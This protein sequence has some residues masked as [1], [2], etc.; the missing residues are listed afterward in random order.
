MG[1]MLTVA[2]YAP[3]AAARR[4]IPISPLGDARP[5]ARTSSGAALNGLRGA[6]TAAMKPRPRAKR[7]VDSAPRRW[8]T[9]TVASGVSVF[10]APRS[11]GALLSSTFE[12][13][14]E[15]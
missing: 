1:R 11:R 2:M 13:C 14:S 9:I 3:R 8:S 7:L 5:L 4:D 6:F 15:V 10:R 12:D